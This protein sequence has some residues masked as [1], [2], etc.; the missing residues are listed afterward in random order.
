[1]VKAF[2]CRLNYVFSIKD[3]ASIQT[4]LFKQAMEEIMK[5][6]PGNSPIR[7]VDLNDAHDW[8]DVREAAKLAVRRYQSKAEG[9]RGLFRRAG[10]ALGDAQP[11]LEPFQNIL[12]S[13]EYTSIVCGG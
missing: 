6:W 11:T 8:K 2:P 7:T 4:G 3:I 13:G 9:I 5:A 10:R 12:P 1:M